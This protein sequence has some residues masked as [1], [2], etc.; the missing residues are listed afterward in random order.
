MFD[1][2]SDILQI[3]KTAQ[4]LI[5]QFGGSDPSEPPL[6]EFAAIFHRNI[7]FYLYFGGTTF[8]E[9]EKSKILIQIQII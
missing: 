2:Q 5:D 1:D 6:F 9:I 8:F 3:L 4:P 7:D